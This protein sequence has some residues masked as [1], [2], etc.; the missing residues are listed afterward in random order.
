MQNVR[1]HY[2]SGR[3]LIAMKNSFVYFKRSDTRYVLYEII[4]IK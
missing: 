4:P 1:I 3:Y 2:A